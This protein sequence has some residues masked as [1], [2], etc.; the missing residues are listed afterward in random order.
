MNKRKFIFSILFNLLEIICT[1]IL[2]LLLKF[3]YLS[4]FIILSTWICLRLLLSAT[5]K[6]RILH[7]KSPLKCFIASTLLFLSIF[8]ANKIDMIVG[9]FVVVYTSIFMSSL[10]NIGDIF[11]WYNDGDIR[12]SKYKA[13]IEFIRNNPNNAIILEYEKF[14]RDNYPTRYEIFVE[15]F[16]KRKKYN[17]I[18]SYMSLKGNTTIKQE[19]KIIFASLEMPLDLKPLK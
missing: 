19:C 6:V 17:E 15:F 18:V 2:G 14:W 8:L 11:Q 9:I 1:I 4:I 16:R 13:L 7:Y 12:S 10:G 5:Y 3:S